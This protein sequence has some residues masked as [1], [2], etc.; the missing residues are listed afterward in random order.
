MGGDQKQGKK[1]GI[2][3]RESGGREEKGFPLFLFCKES[4]PVHSKPRRMHVGRALEFGRGGAT[5]VLG[6]NSEPG[7]EHFGT[8]PVPEMNFPGSGND[9]AAFQLPDPF[10]EEETG[11]KFGFRGEDLVVGSFSIAV[12]GHDLLSK[13]LPDCDAVFGKGKESGGGHHKVRIDPGGQVSGRVLHRCIDSDEGSGRFPV[14][15]GEPDSLGIALAVIFSEMSFGISRKP[16]SMRNLREIRNGQLPI[17]RQGKNLPSLPR[18][19]LHIPDVL[20]ALKQLGP[21]STPDQPELP[22]RFAG[23]PSWY[24]CEDGMPIIQ[25]IIITKLSN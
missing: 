5:A 22:Q 3:N 23:K 13:F 20:T 25:S 12:K 19:K 2:E 1:D 16:F 17:A 15:D 8:G 18:P 7:L 11:F 4:V 24:H 9:F 21:F 6:G 10:L 14:Q